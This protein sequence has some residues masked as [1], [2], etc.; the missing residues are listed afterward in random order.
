MPSWTQS[1]TEN[2]FK[3]CEAAHLAKR[4]SGRLCGAPRFSTVVYC[5]AMRK[6]PEPPQSPPSEG[7]H[8]AAFYFRATRNFRLLKNSYLYRCCCCLLDSFV[9]DS[10]RCSSTFHSRVCYKVTHLCFVGYTRILHSRGVKL[11]KGETLQKTTIHANLC[12]P[13]WKEAFMLSLMTSV[14]I[15]TVLSGK[16]TFERGHVLFS[17]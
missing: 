9:S 1:C 4:D 6:T 7:K 8:V 12:S 17:L 11:F 15:L 16:G 2:T 3:H 13:L 10:P 5:R 14:T